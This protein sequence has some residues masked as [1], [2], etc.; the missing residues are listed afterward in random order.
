VT[1]TWDWIL[2]RGGTAPSH[3]DHPHVLDRALELRV[4]K[5]HRV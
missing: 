5:P 4:M 2:A 1:D 3:P